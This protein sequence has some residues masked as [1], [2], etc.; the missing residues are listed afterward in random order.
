MLVHQHSGRDDPAHDLGDA[1]D[2]EEHPVELADDVAQR[3]TRG[4]GV[5]GGDVGE[6]GGLGRPQVPHAEPHGEGGRHERVVVRVV[7]GGHVEHVGTHTQQHRPLGPQSLNDRRREDTAN[8]ETGVDSAQREESER[9][10]LDDGALQVPYREVGTEDEEEAEAEDDEVLDVLEVFALLGES[11]DPGD[12]GGGDDFP[13]LVT[14]RGGRPGQQYR[15][16]TRALYRIHVLRVL[17]QVRHRLTPFLTCAGASTSSAVSALRRHNIRLLFRLER[18][19][20]ILVR[21][22]VIVVA[23]FEHLEVLLEDLAGVT[24]AVGGRGF[25]GVLGRD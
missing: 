14:E 20:D 8:E 15:T 13:L 25:E 22:L 21:V 12:Q 2:P 23:I 18:P 7:V 19:L 4:F 5:A 6:V 9:G 10:V 24:P 17:Q 3:F 1:E 11:R 16:A